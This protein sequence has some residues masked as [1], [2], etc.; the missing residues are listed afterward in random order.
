M[1]PPTGPDEHDPA[2]I[3]LTGVAPSRRPEMIRRVSMVVAYLDLTDPTP[4]DRAAFADSLGVAPATFLHLVKEW[5]RYG[6]AADMPGALGHRGLRPRRLRPAVQPEVET[7]VAATIDALGSQARPSVVHAVVRSACESRGLKTPSKGTVTTRLYRSRGPA[8][9]AAAPSALMV[10]HCAL[11]LPVVNGGAVLAPV[12]TLAF[13][14]SGGVHAHRLGLL[15]PG[16]RVTA[17][18]IADALDNPTQAGPQVPLLLN[19]DRTRIWHA[20]L[21][22]LAGAG[23]ERV[24]RFGRPVPSG[25]L[26][27]A[28]FGDRIAGFRLIPNLT[29]RSQDPRGEGWLNTPPVPLCTAVEAVADALAS[30]RTGTAGRP[31]VAS[32]DAE[33]ELA[34]TLRRFSHA[35][36]EPARSRPR[37]A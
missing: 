15:G 8:T 9:G 30:G 23:V 27:R 19:A 18:I 20:L 3:D 4:E 28:V 25:R 37:R 16:P 34:A 11:G 10:D 35:P 12:L 1:S 2:S 33:T 6:T 32:A 22:A 13:D 7:V 5:L 24:V 21:D 14:S 17:G 36:D 29:H 26:A 31:A